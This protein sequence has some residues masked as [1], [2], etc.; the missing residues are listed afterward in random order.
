M[1]EAVSGSNP[2]TDDP[3][4]LLT[5][6][7]GPLGM[8]LTTR[9]VLESAG[10]SPFIAGEHMKT[11]DP[12]DTG[13]NALEV[14][15]QVPAREPVA[16]TEFLGG[17]EPETTLTEEDEAEEPGA[18]ECQRVRQRIMWAFLAQMLCC[19]I[20]FPLLFA[21]RYLRLAASLPARPAGH[22]LT[23]GLLVVSLLCFLLFAGVLL[24]CEVF[25]FPGVVPRLED[26]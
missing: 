18:G 22:A 24:T 6:F 21:P 9:T 19:L 4:R 17:R 1:I 23:V 5:V 8:A 20:P 12:F 13:A 3:T 2:D 7:S 26:R 16:A 15:V 10:F 25:E 11:L 14:A